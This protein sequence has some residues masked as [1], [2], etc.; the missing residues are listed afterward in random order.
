MIFEVIE[1]V[2]DENG[3]ERILTT[4]EI[5]ASDYGRTVDRLDGDVRLDR[6]SSYAITQVF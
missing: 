4:Y 3:T 5:S 1:Y 2:K 6:I